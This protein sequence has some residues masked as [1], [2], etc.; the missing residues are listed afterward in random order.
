MREKQGICHQLCHPLAKEFQREKLSLVH[1]PSDD[2]FKSQWQYQSK[3]LLWLMY[4]W[5]FALSFGVGVIGSLI[6]S[7]CEG[8][9]LI[10]LT[11]W[12]FLLCL[13]TGNFGAVLA[14]MHYCSQDKLAVHPL[15]LKIYWASYWT[16]LVMA[17]A[18]TFIYWI[19]IF[20]IDGQSVWDLYNMWAH[21]FNSI[22]MILDHML[23]AFPSRIAHT[24]YPLV[25]G[26]VYGT[27]S[28]IYYFAGG[29]DT[30]GNRYIY[31]IL[32]WSSPGMAILTWFSSL[33]M[34]FVLALIHFGMYKLRIFIYR[35]ITY[36]KSTINI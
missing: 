2:F 20:P 12:G 3:S 14:T 9:W 36:S 25:L 18:I 27:F 19:F 34:I 7:F 26:L 35:K 4:R 28:M 8:K 21:G 16:T 17:T 5:L 23:V 1:E 29:L 22:L 6:E 15:A 33:L 10:Y 31:P 30:F 11:D 24:A 32:D 13:Y